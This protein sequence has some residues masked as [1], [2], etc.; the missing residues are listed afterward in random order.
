MNPLAKI[1]ARLAA[2]AEE[3]RGIDAACE[4]RGAL[5]LSEDENA[6]Y[7]ALA[8]ERVQLEARETQLVD[9]DARR[10]KLAAGDPHGDGDGQRFY[11]TNEPQVY[12]RGSRNSYFLDLA[13]YQLRHQDAP[14]AVDRLT[15]HAQELDVELPKREAR[16]IAR[17]ERGLQSLD[18]EY[19]REYRR[20]PAAQ[21]FF[22][23][24]GVSGPGARQDGDASAELRVNP[25]RT[26]GQGGF[27]TVAAAAA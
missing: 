25:N 14:A 8:A 21:S 20:D 19:A 11:V 5:T 24:N 12:G 2:I 9:E 23:R 4:S 7:E 18:E 1:R 26:D 6:R 3:I 17:A 10:Q 13:R 27:L 22:R 15:R 16:R